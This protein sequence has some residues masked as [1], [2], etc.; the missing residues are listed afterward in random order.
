ME[1]GFLHF[2]SRY[3]TEFGDVRLYQGLCKSV[4]MRQDL[5]ADPSSFSSIL[6]INLP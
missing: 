6:K 5:E 4:D 1:L 3:R 2:R